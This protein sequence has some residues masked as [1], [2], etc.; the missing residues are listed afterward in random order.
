MHPVID[1]RHNPYMPYK[2]VKELGSLEKYW[3]QFPQ[4]VR[5]PGNGIDG[6]RE[7]GTTVDHQPMDTANLH[8][9]VPVDHRGCTSAKVLYVDCALE[10]GNRT[11]KTR[12]GILCECGTPIMD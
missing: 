1:Y 2:T 12:V 10:N 6:Y 9:L 7:L 4:L 5:S 11:S 8:P 3:K